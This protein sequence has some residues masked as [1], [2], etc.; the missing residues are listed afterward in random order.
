VKIRKRLQKS[1][2]SIKLSDVATLAGV[3]TATVSRTLNSPDKVSKTIAHRVREAINELG[4]VPDAAAR[5]LASR[6][7]RAIGALIPTLSNPIFADCIQSVERHLEGHGYALVV[8]STDY[9]LNKEL[10]QAKALLEHG[11]D[12]LMLT[13]SSHHADLYPILAGRKIPYVNT[14]AITENYSHPYVG[15]DNIDAAKRLTD[16]LLDLGHRSIAVISGISTENDRVRDRATGVR[17]ALNARDRA[18]QPEHLIEREYGIQQGRDAMRLLLAQVTL[19]SAVIGGN[20]LLALGALLE[21]QAQGLRV[22][23][24]MSIAGFD[25]L[26]L[27][28]HVSPAL[29][30]MRVP[31]SDMGRLAADYLLNRLSGDNLKSE[32]TLDV[33]LIVRGSTA[34]PNK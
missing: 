27:A 31:T 8:A 11:I 15:I 7:S 3:S 28:S 10:R 30:T 1:R 13:G 24:D 9:M 14:W 2:N 21:C 17:Q 20:D 18:L 19:P 25:D 16:Y 6:R 22:P 29:T 12:A 4:Y 23:S 5:A 33:E 32:K 34:P 26:D